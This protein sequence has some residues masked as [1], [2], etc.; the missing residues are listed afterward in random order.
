MK[1][2]RLEEKDRENGGRVVDEGKGVGVEVARD[3]GVE[4]RGR[5]KRGWGIRVL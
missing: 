2:I 4:E 5:S 3:G 1:K